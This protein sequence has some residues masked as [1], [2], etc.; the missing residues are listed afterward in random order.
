MKY[1]THYKFENFEGLPPVGELGLFFGFD[2]DGLTWLLKWHARSD[3][4]YAIGFEPDQCLA[5]H[6]LLKEDFANFIVKWSPAP[7][8]Y[9]ETKNFSKEG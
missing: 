5:R 1:F 7:S 8:T 6:M 3:C 2:N 4:F 9:S